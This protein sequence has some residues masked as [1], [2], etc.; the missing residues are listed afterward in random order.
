MELVSFAKTFFGLVRCIGRAKLLQYG[1][2][3]ALSSR[4]SV[5]TPREHDLEFLI[6]RFVKPG[7]AP[8]NIAVLLLDAPR[9]TLRMR[10]P[11][12][13]HGFEEDDLELLSA[14]AEDLQAKAIEFGA[15]RLTQYLEDTLSSSLSLSGRCCLRT[16]DPDGELE[17]LFREHVSGS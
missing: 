8:R 10:F 12:S 4:V 6:L 3:H 2:E 9:E 15:L 5:P 1:K 11:D 13:W 16:A 14:L 17:R 7:T